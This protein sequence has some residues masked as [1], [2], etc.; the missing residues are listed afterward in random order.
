MRCRLVQLFY[1]CLFALAACSPRNF[2]GGQVARAFSHDGNIDSASFRSLVDRMVHEELQKR[3][4]IREWMDQTIVK[5]T[6]SA[7]DSAGVQHVIER[8]TTTQSGRKETSATVS[9][10]KDEK[11]LEQSDSTVL[12]S[13]DSTMMKEEEQTFEREVKGWLPWYV[14]AA[15]LCVAVLLGAILAWKFKGKII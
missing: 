13:S 11:T 8:T 6:L 4:D 7:P 1:V 14:Y 9:Q 10:A 5:E 3:L 15:A 2:S 12:H